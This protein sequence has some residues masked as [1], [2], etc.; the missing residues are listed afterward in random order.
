MLKTGRW[1]HRRTNVDG[2]RVGGGGGVESS[3][4]GRGKESRRR[5]DVDEDGACNDVITKSS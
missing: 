1:H 3:E 2:R 4:G 5:E